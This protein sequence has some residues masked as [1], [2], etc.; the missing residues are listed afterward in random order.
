MKTDEEILDEASSRMIEAL[1]ESIGRYEA[2]RMAGLFFE[3]QMIGRETV[4]QYIL[5][6]A[7]V[8]VSD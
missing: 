4:A 1:T 7:K 2:Q 5:R 3:I 6:Q 8:N